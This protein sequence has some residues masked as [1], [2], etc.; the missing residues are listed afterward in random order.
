MARQFSIKAIFEG[1]DKLTAPMKKIAD[2]M[3]G[4]SNPVGLV[5]AGFSR[6]GQTDTFKKLSLQAH[7]FKAAIGKA[8]EALGGFGAGLAVLGGGASVSEFWGMLT[9]VADAGGALNDASKKIG[10]G[11]GT[12]QQFQYAAK[13]SGVEAAT[14]NSSMLKLSKTAGEAAAGSKEAQSVFSAL[15][16]KVKDASGRIK[17]ADVLML[18]MAD[19]MAKIKDPANQA[20]VAMATMGKSGAEMIPVLAGGSEAMKELMQHYKD[21]GGGLSDDA[22]ENADAFGD[23]LDDLKEAFGSVS[24]VIGGQLFPILTPLIQDFGLWM[25]RNKEL[26]AVLV[27]VGTA[28]AILIASLATIGMFGG[29][30]SSG[31]AMMVTAIMGVGKAFLVV[32]RLFMANP[33]GLA[34]AAIVA[35]AY[36]IYENWDGIVAYFQNAWAGIKAAF[37]EGFLNGIMA[38]LQTFNPA[39]LI[40]DAFNGLIEYMFGINLKDAGINILNSLWDGMKEKFGEIQTWFSSVGDQ[41]GGF[42]GGAAPATAPANGAPVVNAIAAPNARATDTIA[43]PNARIAEAAARP[44]TAS[45]KVSFDNVPPGVTVEQGK[46]NV[47][48][49]TEVNHNLGQRKITN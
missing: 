49:K 3:K 6:I 27:K 44:N 15:G 26:V 25:G 32:S 33:I 46:G 21:L 5:N 40:A 23:A 36:I 39:K 30:V 20:R 35:A 8:N 37:D 41:I 34:I 28:A 2:G 11:A 14:L 38:V 12:L 19:K 18:E 31:A 47:P 22:I 10:I 13:L 24:G 45:V 16:I 7:Q 1:V 43:A 4:L 48:T 9:Q 29:I 17:T 42:F